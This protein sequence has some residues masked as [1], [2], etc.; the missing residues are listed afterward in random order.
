[1]RHRVLRGGFGCSR[2]PVSTRVPFGCGLLGAGRVDCRFSL[3]TRSGRCRLADRVRASPDDTRRP[4]LG[5]VGRIRH[6]VARMTFRPARQPN[7]LRLRLR[8]VRPGRTPAAIPIASLSS[9]CPHHPRRWAAEAG[10]QGP[11]L[12]RSG[13]PARRAEAPQTGPAPR[14]PRAPAGG[15]RR[16][17]RVD[18]H[19]ADRRLPGAATS[20]WAF[21]GFMVLSGLGLPDPQ[22]PGGADCQALP[23]RARLA[24]LALPQPSRS[25]K[26]KGISPEAGSIRYLSGSSRS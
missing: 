8:P 9:S 24:L 18:R 10:P 11:G 14:G 12:P 19:G 2:S 6:G 4:I 13:P 25:V 15:A 16:R 3:A 20:A 17:R 7:P 5:R 1:M 26:S 22:R 21:V 23:L